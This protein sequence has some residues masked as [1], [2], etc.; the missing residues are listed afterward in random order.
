MSE[1]IY[2]YH[3]NPEVTAIPLQ[4]DLACN[5]VLVHLKEK[6]LPPAARQFLNILKESCS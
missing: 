4:E 1:K 2:E 6:K 5:I 3:K